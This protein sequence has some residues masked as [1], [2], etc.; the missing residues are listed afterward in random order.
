IAAMLLLSAYPRLMR[1]VDFDPLFRLM[2]SMWTF[3]SAFFLCGLMVLVTARFLMAIVVPESIAVQ[4]AVKFGI[5]SI[6]V[7]DALVVLPVN[8]VWSAVSILSL[9]VP[10]L[11]IG[12]WVYS[13]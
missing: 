3:I 9:L 4:D 10:A 1:A 13:T 11:V 8:G 5:L 12:R 7:L 2:P 6:I